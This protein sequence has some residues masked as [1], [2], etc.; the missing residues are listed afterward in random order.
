MAI[1]S[2]CGRDKKLK[3]E[4]SL[5]RPMKPLK[6][7][8]GL[9]TKGCLPQISKDSQTHMTCRK[10]QLVLRTHHINKHKEIA[11]SSS[12]PS[13]LLYLFHFSEL[14]RQ[15]FTI[16]GR[17]D[18]YGLWSVTLVLDVRVVRVEFIEHAN[19]KKL[20]NNCLDIDRNKSATPAHSHTL[21]CYISGLLLSRNLLFLHV[22]S[23]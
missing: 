15:N 22:F 3:R 2:V 7:I 13:G 8:R 12:F 9:Q 19:S 11:S 5:D 21:Y 4:G 1:A 17:K 10:C 6:G 16:G 23:R 18:F 20:C 14:P